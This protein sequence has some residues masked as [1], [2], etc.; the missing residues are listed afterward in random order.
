MDVH[1]IYCFKV[2]RERE[3]HSKFI[4]LMTEFENFFLLFR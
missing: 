1:V 2:Y 3:V 4:L